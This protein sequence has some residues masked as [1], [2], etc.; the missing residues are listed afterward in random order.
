MKR[1]FFLA[2]QVLLVLTALGKLAGAVEW[3]AGHGA[4]DPV[5]RFISAREMLIFAALLELVAVA[6]IWRG[7]SD[8]Q[9]AFWPF[10][11]ALL[12]TGYRLELWRIGFTG[13]CSCLGSWSTWLH[14]SKDQVNI[15]AKSMIAFMLLGSMVIIVS[16]LL[17]S[18]KPGTEGSLTA[19]PTP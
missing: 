10:W 5:V 16:Q 11:L 13:Y 19:K 6:G 2:T 7:R 8:S 9:K 17:H 12:F 14:L 18:R 4:R 3:V 1:A 15:V